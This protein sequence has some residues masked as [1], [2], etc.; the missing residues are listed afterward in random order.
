MRARDR[1]RGELRSFEQVTECVESLWPNQR[2]IKDQDLREQGQEKGVKGQG[3]IKQGVERICL[4]GLIPAISH[5]SEP[6]AVYKTRNIFVI[7]QSAKSLKTWVG[8]E[9]TLGGED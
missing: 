5:T 2:C 4:G 1:E 8:D 6:R 9:L 3:A 7:S